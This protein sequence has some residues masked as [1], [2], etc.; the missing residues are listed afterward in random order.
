MKVIS[1]LI[2]RR[3]LTGLQKEYES[4]RRTQSRERKRPC[5]TS[6]CW[7]IFLCNDLTVSSG[8]IF[9]SNAISELK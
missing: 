7:L 5:G 1:L 9:C 8:F 2:V 6:V 3:T 4:Y